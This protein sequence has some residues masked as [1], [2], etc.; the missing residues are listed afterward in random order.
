MNRLLMSL[1]LLIILGLALASCGTAG[2]GYGE[3]ASW[4]PPAVKAGAGTAGSAE[5]T[6]G[7]KALRPGCSK[8]IMVLPSSS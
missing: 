4:V 3:G 2:G 6:G 8:R 1:T 7:S 5:N